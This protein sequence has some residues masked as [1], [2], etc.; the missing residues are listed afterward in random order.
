VEQ[1][2]VRDRTVRWRYYTCQTDA[3]LGG[4]SERIVTDSYSTALEIS[5]TYCC[6]V[7]RMKRVGMEV[8]L[9]N[10]EVCF[11]QA[12]KPMRSNPLW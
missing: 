11:T 8:E 10:V 7:V 4:S 5:F 9:F 6:S 1:K 12:T 2:D 3:S